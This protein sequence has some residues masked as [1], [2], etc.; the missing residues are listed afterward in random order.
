MLRKFFTLQQVADL[1]KA[2]QVGTMNFR[3]YSPY[4]YQPFPPTEKNPTGSGKYYVDYVWFSRLPKFAQEMIEN[5]LPAKS[6]S[7]SL[8]LLGY[9]EADL[10]LRT[11]TK[12]KCVP[13]Y[14]QFTYSYD[15]DYWHKDMP[16][17]VILVTLSNEEKSILNDVTTDRISVTPP[18]PYVENLE[19]KQLRKRIESI[20]DKKQSY[21]IKLSGTS[22][23]KDEPPVSLVKSRSMMDYLT[24]SFCFL[25]QE[26]CQM[27]KKTSIVF[28]PWND[29]I[30]P[31]SEFRVFVCN[32]HVTAVTQQ[33]WSRDF[34]YTDQEVQVI[35]TSIMN[36]KFWINL[37][38][39]DVVADVYVDFNTQTA[40]LIECNPF[41]IF[42]P[43]ASGLFSWKFDDH[44]LYFTKPSQV[45]EL[46]LVKN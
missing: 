6:E 41:G 27:N 45:P 22:S 19:L 9:S 26:Y 39:E 1:S 2:G 17:G 31:K 21:F 30:T 13:I 18:K 29:A 24:R 5:A 40:H 46:R 15:Y 12:F 4:Y 20:I 16:F 32:R 38:Y 28:V 11:K 35:E 23:K 25:S 33:R 10:K 42:G 43:S 8:Q 44:I 37:P 3:E 7:I 34:A 14:T 36:S